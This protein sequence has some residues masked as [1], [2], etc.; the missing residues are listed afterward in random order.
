MGY[1]NHADVENKQQS[2]QQSSCPSCSESIFD[3]ENG[4]QIEN[5]CKL[6]SRIA[7]LYQNPELSDI[8][9]VVGLKIFYAHKLV[10]CSASEV[11][12]VMFTN[13]SWC[14]SSRQKIVLKE[15]PECI[16]VFELFLRYLYTG[17]IRLTHYTVLYVLMLA[18]KYGVEDL[19]VIIQLLI[20][21]LH[22]IVI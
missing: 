22:H 14:E 20:L 1:C 3:H 7:G 18:D 9:I 13:P 11:F 21:D 15:E 19:Q 5:S 16:Q 6:L 10:L 2:M 12:R 4:Q 8:Q 17:K